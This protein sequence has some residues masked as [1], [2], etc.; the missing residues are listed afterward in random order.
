[1]SQPVDTPVPAAGQTS[2]TPTVVPPQPQGDP[3]PAQT[4]PDA[5][6]TGGQQG[7][8]NALGDA[9]KRALQAEREARQKAESRAAALEKQIADA[10]KTAE[11]KAADALRDAQA[12]AQTNAAKALRYEVAAELGVPLAMAARLV[13]N[14]RE[15]IAA[16]A[17]VL[18]AQIPVATTPP[19]GGA[20]AA[21]L[22]Q[23]ARTTPPG[24]LSREELAK[25]SPAE[26]LEAAKQGRLTQLLNPKG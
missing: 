4:P 23:G 25:L 9:G 19:T 17:A 7:D 2:T 6:A 15:E 3:A 26:L 8:P 13:G 16:D 21:P 14:T 20:P 18:L 11:E 12:L 10:N 1:M 24:Q 22:D 5:P